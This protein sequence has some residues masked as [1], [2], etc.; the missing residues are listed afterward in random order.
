MTSGDLFGQTCPTLAE[1]YS[2]PTS[3]PVCAVR[4]GF[5]PSGLGSEEERIQHRVDRS[6]GLDLSAYEVVPRVDHRCASMS[7]V[8]TRMLV[9]L[10]LVSGVVILVAFAAQVLIV[11]GGEDNGLPHGDRWQVM[12]RANQGPPDGDGPIGLTSDESTIGQRLL[13]YGLPQVAPAMRPDSEVLINVTTWGTDGVPEC[14]PQVTN[15][16]GDRD[17]GTLV[18]SLAVGGND[19]SECS[20]ECSPITYFVAV[21]RS[22]VPVGAVT[23]SVAS[24]GGPLDSVRVAED[25]GSPLQPTSFTVAPPMANT[26]AR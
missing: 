26:T 5:D 18:L 6:P 12:A 10:A 3:S 9:A 17:G 21:R 11:P 19:E 16:V 23:V 22:V 20:V 8:S 13:E 25:C 24:D 4:V 14:D 1:G 15:V 7:A 2:A